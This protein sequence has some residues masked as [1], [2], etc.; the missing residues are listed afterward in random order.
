MS[1]YCS[2]KHLIYG[3][4]SLGDQMRNLLSVMR[5]M[6]CLKMWILYTRMVGW[7]YLV[8][9]RQG[10]MVTNK[11]TLLITLP[12]NHSN[13]GLV[14]SLVLLGLGWLLVG[15][16]VSSTLQ[17][18]IPLNVP[19]PTTPTHPPATPTHLPHPPICHTHYVTTHRYNKI[20]HGGN[21]YGFAVTLVSMKVMR[22]F[23]TWRLPSIII[24][25]LWNKPQWIF[26][27]C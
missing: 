16:F 6:R 11:Q 25:R 22:N 20:L 3:D 26:V 13:S 23:W 19:P 18:K 8:S 5:W 9:I 12:G 24:S 1:R 7:N 21:F 17:G 27:S 15:S 2:S 14:V 4:I 10:G